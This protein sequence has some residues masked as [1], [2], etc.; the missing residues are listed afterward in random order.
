M[1]SGTF[2]IFLFTGAI[3]ELIFPPGG[4]SWD[5]TDSCFPYT[6]GPIFI[7]P[8]HFRS[9]SSFFLNQFLANSGVFTHHPIFNRWFCKLI[10]RISARFDCLWVKTSFHSFLKRGA[11]PMTRASLWSLWRFFVSKHH[12]KLFHG[13]FYRFFL[14]NKSHYNP[15]VILTDIDYKFI[16]NKIYKNYY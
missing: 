6:F 9:N 8:I 16:C 12:C 7:P 5:L 10:L 4:K 14:C 2:K 1:I 3:F 15:T 13:K 11:S